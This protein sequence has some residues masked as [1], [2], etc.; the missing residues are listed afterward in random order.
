MV[1][2]QSW[3]AVLDLHEGTEERPGL[4]RPQVGAVHALLGYWTTDPKVPATIV[5]P[6]GTGKTDSMVAALVAARISKLLVVVP[7]DALR[8]QIAERFESLGVL[9]ATGLVGPEQKNPVVARLR[10]ALTD[11]ADVDRLLASSDVVV[12]TP[13]A[14]D[15]S[16][17]G[18][19]QQLLDGFSHLFIDEAHHVGA[20][21]WRAIRDAFLPKPVV[22]FTATPHRADGQH[23]GGSMVYV[24][25]L[26]EAQREG[27]FSTIGYLPVLDLLAPDEAVAM[28]AAGQLR[29]DLASGSDHILMARAKTIARA[30]A[31]TE[32]YQAIAP[33]FAPVVVHNRTKREQRQNAIGA[34]HDRTSRILVCVD[35]FGEGFDLPQLK[36]AAM[37]D[38]HR[39]LGITLQ[40]IGRFARGGVT[41]LGSATVIAA[42]TDYRHIDVL[43][44]LYAEDADWNSIV[45]DLSRAAVDEQVELDEFVKAF[46]HDPD[47]VSIHSVTPAM[48][49]V[50]YRSPVLVWS[51]T[52][53]NEIYDEAKLLTF[54]IPVSERDHVTWFVTQSRA[55]VRWGTI[56]GADGIE[57][58]L[59][60]AYWDP[61]RGLLYINS[62]N[63]DGV[64]EDMAIALVGP[65]ASLIHGERIYRVFHGVDRLTPTNVG[66]LDTRSRARRYTS[67][68]G[69]DVTDGFPTAEKQTKAQTHIAGSGFVGGVPHS[70]AGSRK[71]RVWSHR[72]AP[73]IK[74]WTAWCD[75]IGT[76]LLDDTISVE[77]L[78][79]GFIKPQPI[80]RWPDLTVLAVESTLALEEALANAVLS[81]DGIDVPW[82]SVELD[83]VPHR[84]DE[85]I[86]LTL[87]TDEWDA[88]FLLLLPAS[89]LSCVAVDVDVTVK[90][91]RS[92]TTFGKLATARGLLVN[93][94]GDAIVE[95]PGI[96]LRPDRALLPY[97]LDHQSVLDW[98]DVN[99][100]KESW[101]KERDLLTVQ[102]RM[103]QVTEE[104]DWDLII[105]DD[106]PGE[107]ADIVAL[108]EVDGSLVV[109]LIHCKYSHKD[110]PGARIEDLY[111]VCG[112]SMK[113]ARW[114]R[115]PEGMLRR[116]LLRERDR[117]KNSRPSGFVRGSVAELNEL[118]NRAH[119]LQP[120]YNI[121]VA[122]PGLSA[123]RAS[124]QQLELLASVEV[125]VSEIAAA[126]FAVRC[127]A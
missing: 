26:R 86:K 13:P 29:A 36:I 119:Q 38:Q 89:G 35:M 70:I 2:M 104:G 98:R 59:Y 63:N 30:E 113:S 125:Y 48:S 62:S 83:V 109:N 78:I 34:L 24:F 51:P 18:L 76:K 8:D 33:E 102:G 82:S 60:I 25:P 1:A 52:K 6:T 69:A 116:L 15:S 121:S 126:G 64:H 110:S 9:R 96:L 12:T 27:Y 44:Q 41:G 111:E 23:L 28:A 49:T 97:V 47:P 43:R 123:R 53:L 11:L 5:M 112:Q 67:Y 100:R 106:G 124:A 21:T 122:Q 75:A 72:T 14:L 55:A 115:D 92:D 19:K 80:D 127:S 31:I 94:E 107:I 103:I 22:Q 32:I 58:H 84:P 39:S 16:E 87:R 91:E 120:R 7:S 56:D 4:R 108:R 40:F 57:H 50:V 114:R 46:N 95:P 65:E 117:L 99:I 81:R 10:G 42:Q 79:A 45:E 93:F 105:D 90:R 61:G 37:H 73:G 77:T 17:A 20:P 54:P 71:G 68:T 66:L 85:S 74:E 88:E 101:G 118:I 3:P